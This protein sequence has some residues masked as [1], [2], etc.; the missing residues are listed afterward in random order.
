MLGKYFSP[1]FILAVTAMTK[2][3]FPVYFYVIR[4]LAKHFI[5]NFL[6]SFE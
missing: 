5:Y 4:Y 3:N 1:D 6:V 2:Q